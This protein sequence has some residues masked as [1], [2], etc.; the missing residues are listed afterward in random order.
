MKN[1]FPFSYYKILI[2]SFLAVF[3]SFFPAAAQR[4]TSGIFSHYFGLSSEHNSQKLQN[5]TNSRKVSGQKRATSHLPYCDIYL[6]DTSSTGW[7]LAN[8]GFYTYDSLGRYNSRTVFDLGNTAVEKDSITYDRNN[9][10]LIN[11]KFKWNSSINNWIPDA[12]YRV[13]R[14]YLPN[15]KENLA[16][17]QDIQQS[18]WSWQFYKSD[19]SIY[20]TAGDLL[21]F[22]ESYQNNPNLNFKTIYT[23]ALPGGS[24]TEITFQKQVNGVW[25]DF[26]KHVNFTWHNFAKMQ[27]ADLTAKRWVNNAWEDI[28][29]MQGSF[30]SLGGFVYTYQE[31]YNGNWENTL[32]KSA[33]IDAKG[34]Y[35][36]S[37]DEE[38][39]NGTWHRRLESVQALTYNQSDQV[40][41]R[42][43]RFWAFYNLSNLGWTDELK[44]VY[45]NNRI[46]GIPKP[47]DTPENVTI[48]PNPTHSQLNIELTEKSTG[49]SAQLSD[50][51]GKVIL[52][53]NFK[54]SEAPKLN[55]ESLKPGVY[56]LTVQFAEG[57]TVKRIIKN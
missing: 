13:V 18:N 12:G 10:E 19:L 35:T 43:Y 11:A 31:L 51:T 44:E 40:T 38:W 30:D 22:T 33:T 32:R 46:T 50:L 34:N 26:E 3:S 24:A 4:S 36:G 37:K 1:L 27:P 23:Y 55:L 48:Y 49:V 8:R 2:C 29:R 16:M 39:I 54:P 5:G 6:P 17:Y 45:F 28:A 25:V 20:N 21:E 52:R 42:V 57:N 14:S 56:L 15:G 41:E 7:R 53:R 47:L 9:K